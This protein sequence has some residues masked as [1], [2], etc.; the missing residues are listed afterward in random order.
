[1]LSAAK[2][3]LI[4][5]LHTKKGRLKSGQCLVEG[6]KSITAAGDAVEFTFT[7]TDLAA[8]EFETLVTTETPQS[9]AAVALIPEW[10][11]DDVLSKRTIVVL[12]SVQD[13]GNVGA[14]VRL[15]LGFDASLLLIE[16][17]DVSSPKVVRSSAGAVFAVP[18]MKLSPS[19]T[20][21]FVKQHE[22]Q[23][24]RLER[25]DDSKP[26]SDITHD[27]LVYLVVGSEGSGISFTKDGQSVVIEHEEALE[28]LNV[29]TAVAISL[30]SRSVYAS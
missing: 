2:K 30:Y 6:S 15:C 4:R 24:L 8:G 7:P 26:L 12:D 10:S 9:I 20:R 28:S 16:S 21:T 13:P 19:E 11:E 29:A 17:A 23:M 27:E 1:M 22:R 3:K 18:W 5:S 25:R 14:I